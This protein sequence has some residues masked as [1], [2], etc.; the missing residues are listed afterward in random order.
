MDT[1]RSFIV[2]ATTAQIDYTLFNLLMD[3]SLAMLMLFSLN[4][5]GEK[6]CGKRSHFPCRMGKPL[7][8]WL[9]SNK[10]KPLKC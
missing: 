9:D 1:C 8:V 3:N 6:R 2:M 7:A 10:G 5:H 4:N